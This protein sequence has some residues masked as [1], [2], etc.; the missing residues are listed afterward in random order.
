MAN[1][2]TPGDKVTHELSTHTFRLIS[3]HKNSTGLY[4]RV[5]VAGDSSLE[6]EFSEHKLTK[7]KECLK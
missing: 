1:D 5:E 4:W 7:V 2:V 6:L 3:R